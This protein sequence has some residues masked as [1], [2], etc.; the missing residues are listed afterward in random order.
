MPIDITGEFQPSDGVHGF[1]LYDPQD[2][3]AGNVNVALTLIAGGKVQV[4]GILGEIVPQTG[5]ITPVHSATEGTLY[6]DTAA[7]IL[8]VN[9]N[10]T[11]G[12]TVITGGG[13]GDDITVNGVAVVGADFDDATPAAPANAQNVKWQKD[14]LAPANVSAYVDKGVANS[15]ATL[16]AGTKVPVAQVQEVLALADL[17]DVTAKTGTGTVVVMQ[18]GPTIYGSNLQS[19][20]FASTTGAGQARYLKSHGKAN[21]SDPVI[22]AVGGEA[23]INLDLKSKGTGLVKV[24]GIEVVSVSGTQTLT[25]KT[26]TSPT[27]TSPV[28]A[29][30]SSAAHAHQSAAGGGTLDAAAIAAGT[31]DSARLAAKNKTVS[32]ILYI[33]NPAATDEIPICYVGD[34]ATVIAVRSVTDAGTVTFNIESRAKF[35]PMTAGTA[36]LTTAQVADTTGEEETNPANMTEAIATDRWLV[37]KASAVAS[38]PMKLWI[39]L[40]MVID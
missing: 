27:L 19:M 25:N 22:E 31:L 20:E 1:N 3:K 2:I 32:R 16:D 6:W 13:G 7:N 28:I 9:N 29:D 15:L 11:T 12:W 4:S 8:Y 5:A 35:T 34:A 23:D 24:N 10:G 26:L 36:V 38:S 30:F 18:N 21:N 14:A 17:S 39:S 33:E 40:E 37:Y